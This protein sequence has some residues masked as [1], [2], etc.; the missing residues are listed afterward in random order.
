MSDDKPDTRPMV[1]LGDD[2][3]MQALISRW[4]TRA[5]QAHQTHTAR[6]ASLPPGTCSLCYGEGVL[7]GVQHVPCPEC[8][9]TQ[10]HAIGVP[11]EFRTST[12]VN[13]ESKHGNQSALTAARAFLEGARDLFLYGG[14][15]AGKTRLACAIANEAYMRGRGGH[16]ERVPMVLHKLQPSQASDARDFERLLWATPLLVLDDVGAERDI[17]TDYTRR[18]LLMIYE[19]RCDRGLRTVWTSNKSVSE[20]G[21]MQDDD[22]LASRIAGRADV[23]KLTTPDQRIARRGH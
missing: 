3:E 18:T 4:Q 14:V 19:E 1:R 5:D 10:T 7:N 8:A 11:Y 22:R 15:G 13:F 2:P 16:F 17:A 20:L 23:V 21:E 9:P 6:M 12:F